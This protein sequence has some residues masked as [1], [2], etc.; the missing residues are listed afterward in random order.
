[1]AR[2]RNPLDEW[3]ENK[4]PGRSGKQYAEMFGLRPPQFSRIRSGRAVLT[5]ERARLFARNLL[6]KN[7]GIGSLDKVAQELMAV[8][9]SVMRDEH[10]ASPARIAELFDRLCGG[11]LL[12]VDYRDMPQAFQGAPYERLAAPAGRAVANGM[13]FAMFSPFGSPDVLASA[14]DLPPV[15]RSAA[16][17]IAGQTRESYRKIRDEALS[18]LNEPRVIDSRLILYEREVGCQL[19]VG[20]QSRLF[21]AVPPGPYGPRPAELWEWITTPNGGLFVQREGLQHDAVIEQFF[22]ITTSWAVHRT[23]P[24][25]KG[26]ISK[27]QRSLAHRVGL[28]HPP[29][30]S[31]TIFRNG[32]D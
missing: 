17:N 3:L 27:A 29:S 19:P 4:C 18:V 6:A 1:M 26:E 13:S 25:T 32:I 5:D 12:C 23:L 31:W 15:V 21:I 7:A 11:G 10:Q 8:A 14:R 28:K 2:A 20:F 9:T 22:P 16:A 30:T 24:Q